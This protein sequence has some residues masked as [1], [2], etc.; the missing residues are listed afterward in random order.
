[1]PADS[2]N[3]SAEDPEQEVLTKIRWICARIVR[4]QHA[5]DTYKVK[6][7]RAQLIVSAILSALAGAGIL[8]VQQIKPAADGS[9]ITAA[10]AVAFLSGVLTGVYQVLGVEKTATLALACEEAFRQLH[11][12]LE[13]AI[14]NENPVPGVNAVYEATQKHLAS[15]ALVIKLKSAPEAEVGE[16]F[17]ALVKDHPPWKFP[18]AAQAVRA[19]GKPK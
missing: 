6:W 2:P 1:M 13:I 12:Q 16:L 4:G 17:A 14:A 3:P 7:Y 9:L 11:A 18:A 19:I 15:F 10:A 5:P 8:T